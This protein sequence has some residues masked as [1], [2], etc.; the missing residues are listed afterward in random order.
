MCKD[1]GIRNSKFVAKTLFLYFFGKSKI[2]LTLR[3][4]HEL[5]PDPSGKIPDPHLN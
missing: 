5:D 1:M 3:N 4:V 2:S